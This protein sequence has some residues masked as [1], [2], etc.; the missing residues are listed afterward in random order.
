MKSFLLL[1]LF[2]I[3]LFISIRTNKK[4]F[5]ENFSNNKDWDS[6]YY[7]TISRLKDRQKYM[8]KQFLNQELTVNKHL[9]QDKLILKENIP[10]LIEEG[11]I[12]K[13]FYLNNK[14]GFK[15]NGS[16]ACFIS[17]CS[18]WKKLK[19]I[20]GEVFLIFED[21]CKILP[22]FKN[23]VNEIYKDIPKDWDMIWL[24]HNKLV[25]E[26][27]K[28]GNI[29]IPKN[30]PGLG[31]NALHHCYMIKKSSIDKLLNILLPI[32]SFLP[33]DSKIRKNFDKFNAY[34]V[35]QNLAIQDRKEFNKS[36]REN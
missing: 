25:G 7:I 36:E 35:K 1:I 9:G 32:N 23:N 4:N 33:K 5:L 14:S 18:L 26:Y 19:N 31:K 24:G 13:E 20:P 30:N 17:H 15:N 34:F 12:D 2:L 28:N 3:I 29:L 11:Y 10:K 6:A 27:I 16:V 8:E 22:N 21:D